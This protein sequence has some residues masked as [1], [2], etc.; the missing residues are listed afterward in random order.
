MRVSREKLVAV[1]ASLDSD[2]LRARHASGT[3]TDMAYEVAEEEMR[4]RGIEPPQRMAAVPGEAPHLPYDPL[5]AI[6][7][8]LT[9]TEAYLLQGR[10][11]AEGINAVVADGQT[12]QMNEF[13]APALGGVRVL[14]PQ[15]A[16]EQAHEVKAAVARGE[17]RLDE[18]TDVGE[19]LAAGNLPP[20][21]IGG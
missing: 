16:L 6:A 12:V 11:E 10:L 20:A 8:F 13:L 17:Y 19:V 3:L 7:S 2:E 4:R 21:P 5:A 1:F 9:A 14:V 18:N 15:S